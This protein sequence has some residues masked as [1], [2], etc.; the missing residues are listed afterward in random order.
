MDAPFSSTNRINRV[1]LAQFVGLAFAT[2]IPTKFVFPTRLMEDGGNAGA[3]IVN[4]FHQ[5]FDSHCGC[6]RRGC[7]EVVTTL[8]QKRA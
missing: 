8:T 4:L 3:A 2:N 6:R 5:C 1:S 7:S